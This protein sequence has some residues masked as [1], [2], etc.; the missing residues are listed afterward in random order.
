MPQYIL[1]ET[2]MSLIPRIKE[3]PSIVARAA[4]RSQADNADYLAMMCHEIGTP[5]T[6]ILMIAQL[7]VTVECSAKRKK[8]YARMLDASSSM[9]LELLKNTL[10]SSK[11]N[12]G[13]ISIENID[14]DLSK[15]AHE[16]TSI[17]TTRIAEKGLSLYVHISKEL[18]SMC[19]GDPL[20]IRQILLNLLS[21]AIK[22]TEK[23]HVALYLNKKVNIYG[24]DQLVLSVADTG[25]GISKT[26][27]KTVFDKY[28]QADPSISRKYGGTGLGL[29]IS[30]DIAHLMHGDITVE[31]Q[32]GIGS[33]FTVTLP[34]HKALTA[35]AA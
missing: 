26:S 18:P 12:A 5:L 20:R 9:I 30:Q 31:S 10:Y 35:S 11:M 15:M 34:L 16:T 28:T 24:D 14:F 6:T 29:S 22:F 23:G 32:P 13:M 17:L 25:I 4:P 1:Q 2:V 19:R 8:E 27:M 33:R 3:F 21:N 7:L